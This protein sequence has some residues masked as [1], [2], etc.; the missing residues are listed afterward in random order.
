MKG[1]R[2][3]PSQVVVLYA[4]TGLTEETAINVAKR[5]PFAT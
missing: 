1:N 2:E 4:N 3:E 5:S